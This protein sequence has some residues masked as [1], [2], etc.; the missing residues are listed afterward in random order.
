[1][2]L[3]Q[4]ERDPFKTVEMSLA[5]PNLSK[6]EW[7][8]VRTLTDDHITIKEI[9]KCLCVGTWNRNEILQGQ[10]INLK[11]EVDY[12]YKKV[13]LKMDILCYLVAKSNGFF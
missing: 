1:M 6:Q 7:E 4:I 10:K 11:N 2:V 5:N 3:S 8:A 9:D 12:N 13:T